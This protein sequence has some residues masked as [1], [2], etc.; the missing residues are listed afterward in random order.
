[1][2][3]TLSRLLLVTAVAVLFGA[4]ALGE[5][6]GVDGTA[7][8]YDTRIEAT[9]GGKAVKLDLTGAGLRKK[10]VFKVYTI[11]SYVEAGAAVRSAEEL[12]AIDCPKQLHLLMQR[13]VAGKEMADAVEQAIHKA[14]GDDAF[15][16]ELKA[17]AET[18]KALEL[19]K[20]DHIYLIN[21]PKK[22]IEYDVAGSKRVLI[23]NCDFSRAI[24]EIYLGKKNIDDDL[25]KAL[26]SRL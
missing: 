11:G 15:P 25:R 5:S 1:M 6:V 12:A 22:G 23:E 7:A 21:I 26:V 18:M 17:L 14:R 4:V 10:L 13:D 19:K 3:K 20:G 9:I 16:A 24:W 2:T 8:R